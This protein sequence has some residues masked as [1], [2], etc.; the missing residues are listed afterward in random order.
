VGNNPDARLEEI[1]FK[2]ELLRSIK[3]S[4]RMIFFE[5]RVA[6]FGIMR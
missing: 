5:N 1:Q 2:Q 3:F 4:L 6:L